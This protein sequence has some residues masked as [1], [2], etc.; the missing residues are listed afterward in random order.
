MLECPLLYHML[1]CCSP[2][3]LQ[4]SKLL[5]MFRWR[6]SYPLQHR[7]PFQYGIQATWAEL[8]LLLPFG[9]YLSSL[10]FVFATFDTNVVPVTGRLTRIGLAAAL[11][12]AQRSHSVVTLLLGLS[13]D[14]ARKYH[15]LAGMAAGLAGVLH[16]VAIV[17]DPV[18][19]FQYHGSLWRHV[20]FADWM[21][22]SGTIAFTCLVGLVLSSLPFVRRNCFEVFYYLH[23]VFLVGLLV[24]AW[25]HA[26]PVLPLIA[27]GTW[28]LD[29]LLCQL[30][31]W[32]LNPHQAHLR[33]IG[34]SVVEV[35]FPKTKEFCYNPGQFVYLSVPAISSWQSHPLSI[36]SAPCQGN[37]VT[38]HVRV[39][40]DWT[41]A[42]YQLAASKPGKR[43][44]DIRV[45]G[46]YGNLS[47][48]LMGDDRKYKKVLLVS[49]GIGGMCRVL[50]VR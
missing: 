6:L 41:A 26:G 42:L 28:G 45:D 40:G 36:S 30:Q 48:D 37:V 22:G 29:R 43:S 35:R 23:H 39:C 12:L 4:S 49:G 20:W 9:V 32:W 10:L 27:C 47:V 5:Y 21:H 18:V 8:L 17:R 3:L 14:R 44:V 31:R 15:R 19:Q 11:V 46:P 50:Y 7:V 25:F 16:T 38:L 24:S 33:T 13:I 2:S 34:S 1:R